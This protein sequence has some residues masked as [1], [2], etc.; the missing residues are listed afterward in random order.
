[1]DARL[2]S[3]SARAR[4]RAAFDQTL[5]ILE[6]YGLA[7]SEEVEAG[8]ERTA[9]LVDAWERLAPCLEFDAV[10]ARCH[11]HELCSP[12][13]RTG[14]QRGKPVITFQQGVIGMTLDVPVTATKYVAFGPTS[15][16]F[17]A[18]VNERFFQSAGMPEPPVEYIN[19]GCLVDTVTALPNQFDNQTLLVVDVPN[20]P[21]NFLGLE[22]QCQAMLQ[23][24]EKLLTADLPLRRLVIRPHP[25]WYNLDLEAWQRLVREHSTRC[26]LSHPVWSLE[27]DLRR[28]SAVVGI[29]SGVLTVAS[30]CGLPAIF[31]ETEDGLRFV[32]ARLP[33]SQGR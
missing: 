13:C 5:R 24:A 9:Y 12:V 18:R 10:V 32:G 21:G 1:M 8:F 25:Y 19:G 23:L 30:A 4:A 3:I 16:S 7:L 33:A 29:L 15:A 14:L 6:P 28:S 31:L 20:A 11:W 17:M 26:E 22:G 27:D 2:H